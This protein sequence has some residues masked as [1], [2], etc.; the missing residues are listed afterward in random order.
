MSWCNGRK[1]RCPFMTRAQGPSHLGRTAPETHIFRKTA[2]R[3]GQQPAGTRWDF[4]RLATASPGPLSVLE[5]T[6]RPSW[7]P[8]PACPPAVAAGGPGGGGWATGNLLEFLVWLQ[9]RPSGQ[10]WPVC[11]SVPCLC[12]RSVTVP[13]AYG[14]GSWRSACSQVPASAPVAVFTEATCGPRCAE[15][16]S[17]AWS[18]GR[19]GDRQNGGR[20]CW[21]QPG[22]A[23][24][25]ASATS[26]SRGHAWAWNT[27]P[28]S[29]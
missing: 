7:G 6:P 25:L 3:C 24:P 20:A 5:G 13:W 29:V 2:Q 16:A 22:E 8:R 12:R 9:A 26:C 11:P 1:S 15:P 17:R 10:G 23:H 21:G 18:S 28:S 14:S 4:S 19:P 27:V